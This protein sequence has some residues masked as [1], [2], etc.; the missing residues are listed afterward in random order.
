MLLKKQY[1]W[2]IYSVFVIINIMSSFSQILKIHEDKRNTKR[3]GSVITK[4]L[5][6]TALSNILFCREKRNSR[7]FIILLTFTIVK[8]KSVY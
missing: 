6:N 1:N 7:M 2:I 5:M 8:Y 3:Q 4:R